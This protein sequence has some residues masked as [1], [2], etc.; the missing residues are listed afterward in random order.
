MT[1]AVPELQMELPLGMVIREDIDGVFVQCLWCGEE[2]VYSAS[3]PRAETIIAGAKQHRV[4]CFTRRYVERMRG[5]I[6]D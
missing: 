4:A 1:W 5:R 2:Q 3:G 6:R